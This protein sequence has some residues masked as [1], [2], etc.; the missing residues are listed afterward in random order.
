MEGL[1]DSKTGDIGDML[2][3]PKEEA[4]GMKKQTAEKQD[5]AKNLTSK[6][7]VTP[8]LTTRI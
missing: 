4:S 5:L 3:F 6:M 2:E 7:N 1:T 8:A